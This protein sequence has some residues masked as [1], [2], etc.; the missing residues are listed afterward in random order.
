M[1]EKD[2]KI[3]E[4]NSRYASQSLTEIPI[5]YWID[6][7]VG[8]CGLSYLC[9]TDKNDSIILMPRISLIENKEQQVDKYKNLFKVSVGISKDDVIR[10]V[11]KSR[12]DKK[13]IKILTT[14]DSFALGKLDYLLTE[15]IRIYVDESQFVL[16]FAKDKPLESI[17]LHKRLKENIKKVSFFSA[18]PPKRE[19]LPD[20]IQEMPAIKY[21]WKYQT[22]ATPYIIDTD[23][24]YLIATKILSDLLDKKECVLGELVFKK[25]VVF[26]NSVEGLKKIAESLNSK[27]DIAYVVGDVIR[28]DMKLNDY[29]NKLEDCSKLPLI[30]LGTTSLISGYDLYDN[31]TINIVISTSS[32]NFTLLDKEL[33]VPQA[34]TRQR[35]DTNPNN[36]KFIF[37]IDVKDMEDK[38]NKL[39]ETYNND[40]KKLS[41][42]VENLNY[43]KDGNKDYTIGFELYE[44]YYFLNEGKFYVNEALLK[45]RKYIFEELFKQYKEG[46]S[47]MSTNKSQKVVKIDVT[48]FHSKQYVDYAKEIVDANETSD[49]INI[50]N[51][52]KNKDWKTYL[53]YGLEKNKIL[54]NVKEAKQFYEDRNDYKGILLAIR[55]MYKIGEF[56]SSSKVKDDLQKLYDK[57]GLKRNAKSTDLYEFFEIE[58]VNKWI[59]NKTIKGIKIKAVK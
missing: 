47:I 16:S 52:I 7:S 42:V 33:D 38:A 51:S 6:K 57:K 8:G 39:E 54:L 17:E 40:Y 22:K 13:A 56:Y 31:E 18:H 59:D 11:N 1:T 48:K 5:G 19:Y 29:A 15:N 27:D 28:N 26:L 58:N 9:L 50:L 4:V 21:Y 30:T 53:S 10:Y 25:A 34:I 46:Y 3:I 14:Y 32:K 36:D 43:L 23:K 41:T 45:A 12:K 24:P 2:I 37:I 20:Y 49:K 44:G 35:L 55:K